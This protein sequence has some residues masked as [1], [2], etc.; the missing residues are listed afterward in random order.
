MS[1]AISSRINRSLWWRVIDRWLRRRIVNR[2]RIIDRWRSKSTAYNAA[3]YA[4]NK[5]I[6]TAFTMISPT[7]AAATTTP[8]SATTTVLS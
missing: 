3:N 8:A 4:A 2:R 6:A 7:T 1:H 5:S